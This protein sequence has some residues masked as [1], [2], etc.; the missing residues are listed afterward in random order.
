MQT[1]NLI[2][3]HTTKVKRIFHFEFMLV[4]LKVA[5]D[6]QLLSIEK[7]KLSLSPMNKG[8]VEGQF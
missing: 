1:S 6:N 8:N 3:V 5:G 7:R 2:Y 4:C